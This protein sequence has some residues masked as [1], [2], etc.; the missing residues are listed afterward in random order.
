MLESVAE[1][2][3]KYGGRDWPPEMYQIPMSFLNML[4]EQPRV[5]EIAVR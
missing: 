1:M 4:D 2:Q 5:E 3:Q